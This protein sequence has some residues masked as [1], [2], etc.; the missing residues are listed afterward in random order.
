MQFARFLDGRPLDD[1]EAGRSAR[2][3]AAA[4]SGVRALRAAAVRARS[5]A[6]RR[7]SPSREPG[8]RP[9]R[10]DAPPT[11]DPRGARHGHRHAARPGQAS[12]RRARSLRDA[13]VAGRAASGRRS[14]GRLGARDS[15]GVEP[16]RARGRHRLV[17][18]AVASGA[19]AR[20]RDEPHGRV[21]GGARHADRSG[22]G[23]TAGALRTGSARRRRLRRARLGGLPPADALHRA[24]VPRLP[25]ERRSSPTRRSLPIRSRASPGASS[26][27][28]ICNAG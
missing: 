17:H 4:E 1:L 25:P 15:A 20:A 10:A 23:R 6:T 8:D 21:P 3:S 5:E 14:R 16:A 2:R 26:P 24:P 7:S 12:A 19:R 18:G 22:A 9:A 27:R 11:R 13:V 28:E